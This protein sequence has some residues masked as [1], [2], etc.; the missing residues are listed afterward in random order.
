MAWRRK[1]GAGVRD[2]H[3]RGRGC[4][5]RHTLGYSSDHTCPV[6]MVSQRLQP[7]VQCCEAN[8]SNDACGYG[9]DETADMNR[10]Q[11]CRRPRRDIAVGTG[12]A[13]PF[14]RQFPVVAVARFRRRRHTPRGSSLSSASYGMLRGVEFYAGHIEGSRLVHLTVRS[15]LVEALCGEPVHLDGEPD[16]AVIC[17]DCDGLGR[18]AGGD[19]AEWVHRRGRRRRVARCR[20]TARPRSQLLDFRR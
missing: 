3:S 4:D 5:A 12:S 7:D 14:A 13:A 1:R 20:I 8:E 15:F 9:P 17:E 6:G 16:L 2:G 18:E 19:P 11:P 10:V